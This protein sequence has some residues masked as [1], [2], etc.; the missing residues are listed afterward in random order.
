MKI[1]ISKMDTFTVECLHN[2]VK[3]TIEL[4]ARLKVVA[5]N[6]DLLPAFKEAVENTLKLSNKDKCRIMD[7]RYIQL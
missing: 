1:D 3:S 4:E 5:P 6:S 7:K 2:F